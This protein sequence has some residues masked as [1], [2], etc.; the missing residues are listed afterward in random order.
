MI[1][2]QLKSSLQD[3]ICSNEK[4]KKFPKIWKS[5]KPKIRSGF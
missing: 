2:S 4:V 1:Y 3:K 5:P